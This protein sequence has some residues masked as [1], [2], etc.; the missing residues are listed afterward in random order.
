MGFELATLHTQGTELTTGPPRPTILGGDG[1]G[2]RPDN[3]GM[4]IETRMGCG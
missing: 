3:D 1:D 2:N 4:G